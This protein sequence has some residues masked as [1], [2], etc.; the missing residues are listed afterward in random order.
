MGVAEYCQL[1]FLNRSK[2]NNIF[3]MAMNFKDFPLGEFVKRARAQKD[4]SIVGDMVKLMQRTAFDMLWERYRKHQTELKVYQNVGQMS[5]MVLKGKTN[6]ESDIGRNF[7]QRLLSQPITGQIYSTSHI[8]NDFCFILMCLD[9]ELY[10]VFDN[11]AKDSGFSQ[12][13]VYDDEVACFVES[14]DSTLLDFLILNEIDL[15]YAVSA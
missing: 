12:V 15:P 11:F 2:A 9:D 4:Q 13:M 3:N 7:R 8:H 5:E 1:L 6:R 10:L 14:E